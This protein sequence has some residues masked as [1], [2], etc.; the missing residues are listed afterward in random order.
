MGSI[1]KKKIKGKI[2]Y[3]YVESK[4]INGKPKYVNQKYL[5]NAETLINKLAYMDTSLQERVLHSEVSEFGA[6]LLLYDIALRLNIVQIIDDIVSKRKQGVSTG[7]YIL[8]AAINRAVAPSS[9]NGLQAWYSSTCLPSVTGIRSNAFTPQNFWNNTCIPEKSI[10]AM[11]DAILRK[12]V[13]TYDIDTTHIIYDATN[14]F[15]YIDTMQECETAKLGHNKEKRNDLRIIGLSLMI[16]ADCSVP[17]LHETYPGNRPDAKQFHVMMEKLKN[18]YE[19]ITG[20]KSDVTVVFDRGNNSEDNINFLEDNDFPIHYVGG[21]RKNQAEELFQVPLDEYDPLCTEAL[22]GQSAYRKEMDVYGRNVT[23]LIVHNP[24]LEKGQL[25]GILINR[26]KITKKLLDLQ[27]KLMRRANGEIVKG[28][29]PVTES[30]IKKVEDILKLE[31]MKDI[32]QYEVIESNGHIYLTFA[33]SDESLEQLWKREL[34]KKVLFTDRIDFTNEDIVSAYRSAWHVESVFKQMKN[35]DHLSVRPVFHWTDE[36]IRVHIFVCVLA[37]RLCCLLHKELEDLGISMSINRLLDELSCIRR[38]DT[39][40]GDINK[41]E[42]VRSFTV[43]S[44]MA[45]QIESLYQ[46]KKK[47]S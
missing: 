47:Y 1:I 40:F 7:E 43:G 4:R 24:E 31:Y 10:D 46:L 20:Q 44:E 45:E 34:G 23:A 22:K 17:L 5:G 32:F 35:T 36:K 12:I 33:S 19:S 41:P 28:K 11:E 13:A 26:E 18:R 16:S 37:Y 14:F 3:Y 38:V 2:Y 39:F 29:A 15:T 42:K 6:V 25:Q 21:L 27:Q 30:T 9:T 8:T